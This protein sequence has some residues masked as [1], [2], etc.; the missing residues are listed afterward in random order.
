MR[1]VT[2]FTISQ[3][4]HKTKIS[5]AALSISFIAYSVNLYNPNKVIYKDI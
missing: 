3:E 2:Q 5:L 1:K 4:R